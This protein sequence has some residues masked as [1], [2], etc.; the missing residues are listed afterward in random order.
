M[1]SGGAAPGYDAF[2]IG[3]RRL[4]LRERTRLLVDAHHLL[5]LAAGLII[6]F[7]CVLYG[8]A[9][10]VTHRRWFTQLPRE[11]VPR[12]LRGCAEHA[13]PS[14]LHRGTAVYPFG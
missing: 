7:E 1:T 12:P 2:A 5:A 3:R 11:I 4:G 9:T 10:A 6:R 8:P 13:N 14:S